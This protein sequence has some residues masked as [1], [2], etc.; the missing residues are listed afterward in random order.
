[1][2][3]FP[4]LGVLRGG[5]VWR[6]G[7]FSS[8]SGLVSP[9]FLVFASGCGMCWLF[10]FCSNWAKNSVFFYFLM[11]FYLLISLSLFFIIVL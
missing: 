9:Y 7:W 11:T 5:R 3:A 10:L 6:L 1:V 2:L 8:A 4:L